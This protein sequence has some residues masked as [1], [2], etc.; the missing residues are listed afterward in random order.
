MNKY[1]ILFAAMAG[2]MFFAPMSSQAEVPQGDLFVDQHWP[3]PRG[4]LLGRREV[5][6]VLA[7]KSVTVRERTPTGMR[8]VT[9]Q[10]CD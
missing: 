4:H 1:C 9:K 8:S 2:L 7:C 10:K 5:R 3:G 6:G